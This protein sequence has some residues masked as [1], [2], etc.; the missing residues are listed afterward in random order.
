MQDCKIAND[1]M[2]IEAK[3]INEAT[4]LVPMAKTSAAKPIAAANELVLVAETSA[5]KPINE[6]VPKDSAVDVQENELLQLDGKL[7][8]IL[9]KDRTT[10]ANIMWCTDDY[11]ELGAGYGSKDQI[12]PE[13][14]TGDKGEVIRPRSVKSKEEQLSRTREKAEVMTPTWICNKMNNLVDEAWFERAHV[15]NEE[16][17]KVWTPTQAKIEFPKHRGKKSWR[18]YIAAKRLEITCG[19]APYLVSRYDTVTGASVPLERRIGLL[20]RK[21]RVINERVRNFKDTERAQKRWY[22]LARIALQSIYGF[23]WQGDNILLARENLLYTLIDYYKAKFNNAAMPLAW[24]ED[25]A[26]II[27]WNIWQMDGIKC[28]VPE[29]CHEYKKQPKAVEPNLFDNR[30]YSASVL[31]RSVGFCD[32]VE[33]EIQK[34]QGCLKDNVD[35][36][37]GKYSKI[38]NW[39]TGRI[40]K[41]KDL[42]S[43]Q[44]SEN[45][46]SK[47][48]KFDVV[49]G[50]PPYQENKENTSDK[51]IYD[52]FMDASYA[53]GEKVLLITP[54]R[55]LFN[56]GKTPKDWNKKMLEDE[57]LKV[58]YYN[59]DSYKVFPT[60]EIKGGVAITMRD[61]FQNIGP[62]GVFTKYTELN[63]IIKKITI[64]TGTFSSLNEYI[65]APESYKFAPCVHLDKPEIVGLMSTGHS[66]DLTSNVFE[67]LRD[68]DLFF[69][70]I[71]QDKNEYVQIFGLEG[72]QR[73]SKYIQKKYIK[74]HDNLFKYKVFVSKS[75]G[76]GI[77]GE[78]MAPM[79]LGEIAVG[80]TQTFISIG[81][82]DTK[83]EAINCMKYLKSKFARALLG[84]LKVT[85][86][87]KKAVW[88]YIPNQ[89]F[90][91]NSDIDW[92]KSISEI[93]QQLYRKYGLTQE[94]INFIETKVKPME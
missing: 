54:A 28:V 37:N 90:S 11:A 60:T 34:C 70:S 80:H 27:S 89:D 38:K 57:H 86:D 42:L 14:I 62:I 19:E 94:E 43:G 92:S 5:A 4:K 78:V 8:D 23:E 56:A 33:A 82:F 35:L 13:L 49:I 58:V 20:D 69:D 59:S 93:D 2:N 48:F 40:L 65:Y 12:M 30:A 91:L 64:Y 24:L 84:V 7:L 75:S 81:K 39:S 76:S 41:F 67:R 17:D 52:K 55:F 73:V 83:I 63:D 50:N 47:D 6:A 15:F 51:P 9:L 32:V 79:Q 18:D 66:N 87:N 72:R 16:P 31:K 36:H 61:M 22:E 53:V 88:Y 68:I 45:S 77:F 26:T 3:P 29:T 1:N 21:L 71:N 46:M 44:G 85:Q 74:P 25:F 10:N